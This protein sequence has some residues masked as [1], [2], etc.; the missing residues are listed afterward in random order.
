[1][2]SQVTKSRNLWMDSTVRSIQTEHGLVWL[3]RLQEKYVK[4]YMH[5]FFMTIGLVN[6]QKDYNL[7]NYSQIILMLLGSRFWYWGYCCD[8][9]KI[10]NCRLHDPFLGKFLDIHDSKTRREQSGSLLVSSWGM[11]E[12]CSRIRENNVYWK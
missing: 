10:S 9:R 5:F 8:K 7:I 3:D 11:F 6:S 4:I 1:M 2:N 12:I